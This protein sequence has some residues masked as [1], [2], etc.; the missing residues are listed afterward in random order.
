MWDRTTD[1]SALAV[2]DAGAVDDGPVGRVEL[3]VRVPF[4]FHGL[5]VDQA[6]LS[7]GLV[8]VDVGVG[9]GSTWSV[10]GFCLRP[11]ELAAAAPPQRGDHGCAL[12]LRPPLR[13]LGIVET[14]PHVL[15]PDSPLLG[16]CLGACLALLQIRTR[17]GGLGSCRI[18]LDVQVL[19]HG[20]G[21]GQPLLQ[22]LD[23]SLQLTHLLRQRGG[24]V[25]PLATASNLAHTHRADISSVTIDD[26]RRSMTRHR[27]LP[28][29]R[30]T[31]SCSRPPG[32]PRAGDGTSIPSRGDAQGA[33]TVV[34]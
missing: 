24:L 15:E 13:C 3:P 19:L 16:P 12:V 9:A 25:H 27:S 31:S 23:L 1:R 30:A 8:D 2:F 17:I 33:S 22:H 20:I 10:R 18:Q 28:A 14:P 26:L 5:G 21:G 32:G 34:D 7:P 11:V 4:G 6:A 29:G